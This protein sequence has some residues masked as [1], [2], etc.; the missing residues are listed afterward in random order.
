MILFDSMALRN[1]WWNQYLEDVAREQCGMP[2]LRATDEPPTIGDHG[3]LSYLLMFTCN[4]AP[5]CDY[6]K[7]SWM[8]LLKNMR[9]VCE[10][11]KRCGTVRSSIKC[12]MRVI[13]EIDSPAELDGAAVEA[14]VLDDMREEIA[15]APSRKCYGVMQSTI[16]SDD[17]NA[18]VF[19]KAMRHAAATNRSVRL[20]RVEYWGNLDF[21]TE[22]IEATTAAAAGDD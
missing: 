18:T 7:C 12:T 9:Q 20:V 11:L 19:C 10:N 13:Q 6:E 8:M 21:D 3:R 4:C 5:L 16:Y 1:D 17:N 22:C 2:Q 14:L 15:R